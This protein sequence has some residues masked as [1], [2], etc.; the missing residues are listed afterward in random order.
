MLPAC[1]HNAT[2]LKGLSK[3]CSFLIF[4]PLDTLIAELH[5][6]RN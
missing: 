4:G 6:E 1:E 3:E 5:L 2:H